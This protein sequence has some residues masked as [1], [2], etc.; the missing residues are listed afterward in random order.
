MVSVLKLHSHYSADHL[1]V[2]VVTLLSS[3][4]AHVYDK[5]CQQTLQ[6]SEVSFCRKCKGHFNYIG[7]QMVG[8]VMR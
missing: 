4:L 7:T 5:T 1:S 8:Q 2:S 6:N 3:I